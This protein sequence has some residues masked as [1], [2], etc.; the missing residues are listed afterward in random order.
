MHIHIHGGIVPVLPLIIGWIVVLAL[1]VL[2]YKRMDKTREKLFLAFIFC[3]LILVVMFLFFYSPAHLLLIPLLGI[4]LG[5]EWSFFV[6]LFLN[7]IFLFTAF[8]PEINTFSKEFAAVGLNTLILWALAFLAFYS[9]KFLNR[10]F[11]NNFIHSCLAAVIAS[12]IY[13][14]TF[15][16]LTFVAGLNPEGFIHF[17]DRLLGFLEIIKANS[18]YYNFLKLSFPLLLIKIITEGVLTG[19]LF[20]LFKR[21]SVSKKM[22]PQ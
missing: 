5:L 16:F 22:L 6:A 4:I 18:S 12:I 13:Y 19:I 1:S 15:L 20:V 9:F 3:A 8:F 21:Y 11:M 10:F 14:F 2:F 17:S 7:I